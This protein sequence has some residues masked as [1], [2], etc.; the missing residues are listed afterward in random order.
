MTVNLLN[1]DQQRRLATHLGLVAAD[2][3]TLAQ[4]PE[5]VSQLDPRVVE[6]RRLLERLAD[7]AAELP[8]NEGDAA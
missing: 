8:D 6:V 3:E 4:S 7:A 1:P 5:L 2:L